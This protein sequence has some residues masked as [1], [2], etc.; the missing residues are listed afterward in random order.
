MHGQLPLKTLELKYYASVS[1][2]KVDGKPVDFT[3]REGT[4]CFNAEVKKTL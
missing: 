4:I 3:F 1:S 2:V